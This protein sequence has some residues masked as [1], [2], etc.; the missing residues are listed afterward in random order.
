MNKKNTPETEASAS[1]QNPLSYKEMISKSQEYK[2]SEQ[3]ELDVQL[4]KS[5]VEVAIATNNKDLAEARMVLNKAK[6]AVPYDLETEL[7]A[8]KNVADLE[9]GLEYAKRVLAE[10]F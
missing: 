4:A 3:V 6:A 8:Y 7:K 2:Q 9:R 5:S 1:N 10:R